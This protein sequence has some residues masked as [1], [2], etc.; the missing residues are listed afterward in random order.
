[1]QP[2]TADFKK[3]AEQTIS[4]LKEDLKA[5]RTGRANPAIIEG[6]IVETYGGST[7]LKLMEISTITTEGPGTLVV[8]PFDPST[9]PDIEKAI[10]KSP[11]GITPQPQGGRLLIRIPPLSQEQREKLMKVISQK[12]EEKKVIIRN[13]RDD[14]RKKIKSMLESKDVTEDAKFRFEKEIDA[15]TSAFMSEIE[16]IKD[17]KEKEIM[18]V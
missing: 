8:A 2:T 4:Q 10:L 12:I 6:L 7:K 16:T 1:M 3:S 11:L 13:H 18:E 17:H 15:A 5:I 9:T 14:A